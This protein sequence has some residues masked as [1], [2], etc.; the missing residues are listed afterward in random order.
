MH[1]SLS[2]LPTIF[3]NMGD[4]IDYIMYIQYGDTKWPLPY[5]APIPTTMGMR[6]SDK[7][8]SHSIQKR[9]IKVESSSLAGPSVSSILHVTTTRSL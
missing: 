5:S 2:L 4:T 6:P 3:P 9:H 1:I 8:V 7:Y